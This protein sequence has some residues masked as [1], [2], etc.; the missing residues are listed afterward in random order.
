MPDK[1][2][3]AFSTTDLDPDLLSTPFRVQTNWHVIA[4]A[5]SCGKTTLI[6]H[7]AN[8]G[9]QTVTE[10][11]RLYIEKEMAKGRGIHPIRS[12]PAG[13]QRK[14]REIQ[15]S[16]EGGLRASD[17]LFLDGALPSSLAWY[18]LYGLNPNE[19]LPEC[20]CHRYASVFILDP[21]PFQPDIERIDELA[22]DVTFLEEW[23]TRDYRALGYSPVRVPVLPP[24][25]RLAFV[26]ER[27]SDREM[28]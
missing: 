22:A 3:L 14:I 10:P 13:L 17:L 6:D 4:G 8:Q 21:L 18:R 7:L 11:A 2:R 26:L 20:F 5:P 27:L 12:N 16:V 28:T 19:I 9:F 15:L 25:E 1:P 23:H 24:E